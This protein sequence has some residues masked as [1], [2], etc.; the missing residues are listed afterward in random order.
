MH[1][2]VGTKGQYLQVSPIPW[3]QRSDYNIL[4]TMIG[5]VVSVDSNLLWSFDLTSSAS[6]EQN[7]P[8]FFVS[9]R[10]IR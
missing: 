9:K 7:F 1:Y 4:L 2:D 10:Y 8:S 5:L 6:I 3:V